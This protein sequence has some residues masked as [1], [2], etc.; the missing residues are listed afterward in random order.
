MDREAEEAHK[1]IQQ[2]KRQI[3]EILPELVSLINPRS[4]KP[5]VTFFEG[6]KGIREA[7][8]DT[9]TSKGEILGYANVQAMHEGLPNFFPEYHKRR[10]GAGLAIKA[11]LT[12]NAM[13]RERSSHDKEEMRRTVFVDPSLPFTPE[14]DIYNDKI[15]LTSW[16]EKL[17][18]MIESKELADMQRVIYELVWRQLNQKKV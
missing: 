13:S 11:I 15:L 16:K 12:D 18:I 7:Y 5:K 8:E 1:A 3:Q 2:K 6:E 17:S 9:L 10:A 14:L 4:T